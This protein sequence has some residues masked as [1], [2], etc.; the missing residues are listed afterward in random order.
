M[1]TSAKQQWKNGVF[2]WKFLLRANESLIIKQFHGQPI[3]SERPATIQRLIDPSSLIL[4]SWGQVSQPTPRIAKR[5]HSRTPAARDWVR[6]PTDTTHAVHILLSAVRLGDVDRLGWW[7]SQSVDEVAEYVRG[8]GV[9]SAL[10]SRPPTR[11]RSSRTSA[12][13][14]S[15]QISPRPSSPMPATARVLDGLFSLPG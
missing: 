8:G 12:G 3:R 15:G 13:T 14:S 2:K 6:M 10:G 4:A 7:R 1:I 11:P 9:R 5:G